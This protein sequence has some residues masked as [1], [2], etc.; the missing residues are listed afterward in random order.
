MVRLYSNNSDEAIS[1]ETFPPSLMQI[2]SVVPDSIENKYNL[3]GELTI[4]DKKG[5]VKFPATIST[6][7]TGNYTLSGLCQLQTL[8][9]PIREEADPA[10]INYDI[11]T[12]NMNVIFKKSEIIRDSVEIK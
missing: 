10:N 11:I 9:W 3:E 6:D 8:N 5:P 7:S 12:L 2:T 1:T 4:K